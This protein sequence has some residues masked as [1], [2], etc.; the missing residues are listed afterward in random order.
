MV[1]ILSDD[2]LA[3]VREFMRSEAAEK[4]FGGLE[5]SLKL[6]W[7]N[8]RNTDDRER[9]WYT[10]QQLLLLKANLQDAPANKLLSVR[11]HQYP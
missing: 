2:E 1:P 4:L 7:Q 9:I 10:L 5:D 3:I 11:R 6:D 8:A